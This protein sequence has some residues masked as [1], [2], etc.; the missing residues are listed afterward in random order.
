MS[1]SVRNPTDM[2]LPVEFENGNE[3]YS[4]TI[5]PRQTVNPKPGFYLSAVSASR[6]PKLVV[7][8]T[9]EKLEV[10][11]EQVKEEVKPVPVVVKEESKPVSTNNSGKGGK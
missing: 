1:T 10:K 4:V 9:P 11:P 8:E 7:T 6:F 2:A 5:L 3:R